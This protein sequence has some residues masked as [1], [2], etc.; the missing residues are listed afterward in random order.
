MSWTKITWYVPVPRRTVP[1]P[2]AGIPRLRAIE[3]SALIVAYSTCEVIGI[4]RD[5]LETSFGAGPLGSFGPP[6]AEAKAVALST[7]TAPV[8][9]VAKAM[10]I[11]GIRVFI[12]VSSRD[13]GGHSPGPR[14][15]FDIRS[16]PHGA[17]YG[18]GAA[19][20]RWRGGG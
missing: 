12:V 14:C 15:G 1:P 17:P 9:M 10:A 11:F 4:P 6:A 2:P 7:M 5:V 20:S 16:P 3:P 18:G 13:V 19:N 8:S